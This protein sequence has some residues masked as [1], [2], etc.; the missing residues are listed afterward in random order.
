LHASASQPQLNLD[1]P[2][3]LQAERLAV[4]VQARQERRLERRRVVAEAAE[5]NAKLQRQSLEADKEAM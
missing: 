1:L 4:L 5:A 2:T 3:F